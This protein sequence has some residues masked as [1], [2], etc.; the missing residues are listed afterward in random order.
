MKFYEIKVRDADCPISSWELYA[1]TYSYSEAQE[2][3][4]RLRKRI[5]ETGSRLEFKIEEH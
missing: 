1:D 5:R 2:I 3:C 4:E